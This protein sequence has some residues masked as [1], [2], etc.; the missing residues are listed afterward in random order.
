MNK[1]WLDLLTGTT[2]RFE[3]ETLLQLPFKTRLLALASLVSMYLVFLVI[4]HL[5]LFPHYNYSPAGIKMFVSVYTLMFV[6]LTGS[7]ILTIIRPQLFRFKLWLNIISV[8]I[9]AIGAAILANQIA[10]EYQHVLGAHEKSTMFDSAPSQQALATLGIGY[11][12][13]FIA[14]RLSIRVISKINI[15]KIEVETEIELA[16]RIQKT[17]NSDIDY[18]TDHYKVYGEVIPAKEVGG[19]YLEWIELEDGRFVL[20]LGDVSGHDTASGLLMGMTKSAFSTEIIYEK[21]PAKQLKSLNNS[22]CQF[23]SNEKFVTFLS[24]IFD[25]QKMTMLC[26]NAGHHPLINYNPESNQIT[27]INP[28]GM[29][30]GVVKDASFGTIK[31]KLYNGNIIVA[32]TDGLIEARN[33]R[34]EEY[35]MDRLK[36]LIPNVHQSSAS[37]IHKMILQDLEKFTGD[38]PFDDDISLFVLKI[39][40]RNT[41]S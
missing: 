35:G 6:G 31:N 13:F 17:I 15:R 10:W 4:I 32:Y 38:V 14:T 26:T 34:D 11:V 24:T 39:G 9:T 30:L 23:S 41:E 12:L 27:E 18:Q 7:S 40:T 19:D 37:E 20:A 16:R 1:Y 22:V 5:G 21:D 8:I 28:D 36:S 29:I 3:Y 33:K 25:F 2:N